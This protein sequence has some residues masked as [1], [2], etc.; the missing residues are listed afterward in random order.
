MIKKRKNNNNKLVHTE[1]AEQQRKVTKDK[2][3]EYMHKNVEWRAGEGKRNKS[4]NEWK[5]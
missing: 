2:M 1:M 3:Q 5:W 4:R